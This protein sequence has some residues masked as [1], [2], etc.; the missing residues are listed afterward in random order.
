MLPLILFF[1]AVPPGERRRG[2][3]CAART[4]AATVAPVAGIFELSYVPAETRQ[5][6]EPALA[7]H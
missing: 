2:G 3:L 6:S 4:P 1:K 7:L 5:G